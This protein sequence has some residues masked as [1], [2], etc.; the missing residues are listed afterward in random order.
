MSDGAFDETVAPFYDA[1][2]AEMFAPDVLE[3]TVAFL[4]ELAGDRPALEFAVGT[5]RV[6]LPLA[7]ADVEVHGIEL[8]RA[9]VA[10]LRRKPD[11]IAS[12]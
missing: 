12:P 1:D 4:A 10:E 9:M 8:S 7:D 6:A 3:P 11:P 2:V 5:G